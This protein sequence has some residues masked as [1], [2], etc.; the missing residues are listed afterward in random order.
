MTCLHFTEPASY[1]AQHP[2]FGSH[3]WESSRICGPAV[4]FQDKW[5]DF[6]SAIWHFILESHKREA[7]G[8]CELRD[9][10][11]QRDQCES[12]ISDPGFAAFVPSSIFDVLEFSD[13]ILLPVRR[14]SHP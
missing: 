5:R 4:I 12:D 13:A 2:H 3:S 9:S 8:L 1:S 7:P 14:T 10:K 6:F 11:R